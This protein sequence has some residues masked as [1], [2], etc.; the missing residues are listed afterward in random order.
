MGNLFIKELSRITSDGEIETLAFEEGVNLILGNSNSGKTIWLKMLDY[1]MGDRGNVED[2]LG[3]ETGLATKYVTIRATI[4]VKEEEFIIERDWNVPGNKGKIKIGADAFVLTSDFSQWILERLDIPM[5]NIP[6]GNPYLNNWIELSFRMMFRHIYRQERFWS[7]FADKQPEFEQFATL[8]QFLGIADKLYSE[9][10]DSSISKTK[11][12]LKLQSRKEQLEEILDSV[13]RSMTA[14]EDDHRIQFATRQDIDAAILE[15][16]NNVST[17]LEKRKNYIAE[18]LSVITEK[19][20]ANEQIELQILDKRNALLIETDSLHNK[21][22][23]LQDRIYSFETLRSRLSSEI[24][25]LNRT[26]VSG[27]ISDLKIT[28]C[29]AC[30]QEIRRHENHADDECFLCHRHT[31]VGDSKFEERIDFEIHQLVSEEKELKELIETYNSNLKE[32]Q[33]QRNLCSEK[34]GLIE[35]QLR[36]LRQE[37]SALTDERISLLDTERGRLEEKIENFKR[38]LETYSTKTSLINEIDELTNEINIHETIAEMSVNK[39]NYETIGSVLEDGMNEYINDLA[40]QNPLIWPHGRIH[41]EIS[42]RRFKIRVGNSSWTSVSATYQEYVLLAYHYGLLTLSN[43]ENFNYPGILI[44]DFPPQ[45]GEE[46]MSNDTLDY[47][48]KPF[49]NFC[50]K[51]SNLQVIFAAKTVSDLPHTHINRLNTVWTSL[52]SATDN[53]QTLS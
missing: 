39:I 14:K 43:R 41:F 32:L 45:F 9:S 35:R 22:V 51:N 19:N 30:D 6:K 7:D 8:S 28:H 40:R 34:L 16:Q 23:A 50:K 46:K 2:A 25:K 13:T 49:I 31:I 12:L 15:L 33:D 38:L 53:Q 5:V 26:K 27:I 4:I 11:D 36:P 20:E 52:D 37:L 17:L 48:I 24:E 3:I 47:L 29:P 44:I 42:E 10:L 21:M 18:Q 1:L